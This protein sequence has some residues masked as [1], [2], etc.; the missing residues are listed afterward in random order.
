MN[1]KG[2]EFTTGISSKFDNDLGRVV[3]ILSKGKLTT[4]DRIELLTIYAPSY[5]DSGK[6]EGI[7]SLDSSCSNCEFCKH[8]LKAAESDETII[9]GLCYDKQQEAYKKHLRNRHSLNMLIMQEIEYTET[10][11][12]H[13][14]LTKLSRINSSGDTPNETYARNMLRLAKVNPW[15]QMGYWAKHTAPVIKACDAVGKPKNVTLIQS[16]IHIG[17]PAKLQRYFDYT[18]TVYPDKEST[19]K[20]I[21]NGASEC[22]GRKCRECGFKCYYGTHTGTDIAEVLRGAN[23]AKRAAIMAACG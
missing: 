10:E 19:L 9:C 2:I 15:V 5:H 14:N 13:V 16:S 21:A 12:A 18:F 17:K 11:L 6:I 1:Y 20:A 7:T 23:K 4:E 22:N 8:M 3:E